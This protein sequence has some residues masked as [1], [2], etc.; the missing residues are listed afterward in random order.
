MASSG[1][2]AT[3]HQP[4]VIKTTLY[5]VYIIY[6]VVANGSKVSDHGK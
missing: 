3:E 1:V 4:P 5:I 6:V 2:A